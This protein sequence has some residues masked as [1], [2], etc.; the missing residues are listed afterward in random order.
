[1]A[2]K[3]P[4]QPRRRPGRRP[5]HRPPGGPSGPAPRGFTGPGFG[6]L[7]ARMMPGLAG[8]EKRQFF[9]EVSGGVVVAAGLIGAGLGFAC[10]GWIGGIL[11]LSL[12]IT[13]GGSYVEKQ[14]Y[15]RR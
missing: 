6:Q 7:Y 9:N 15:Y 12:G 1:M 11:G 4:D 3:Y 8:A 10:L 2:R 14:R 13:V 5:A